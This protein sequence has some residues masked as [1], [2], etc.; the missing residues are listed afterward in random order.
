MYIQYKMFPTWWQAH[1]CCQSQCYIKKWYENRVSPQG[2]LVQVEHP[3]WERWG[4]V[5]SVLNWWHNGIFYSFL[6]YE[7]PPCGN[8]GHE[9]N[10]SNVFVWFCFIHNCMKAQSVRLIE[11]KPQVNLMLM[12]CPLSMNLSV[13]ALYM[14]TMAFLG[15][16]APNTLPLNK[17]RSSKSLLPSFILNHALFPFINLYTNWLSHYAKYTHKITP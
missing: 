17:S 6:G 13:F 3:H 5:L 1:T 2:N 9:W 4:G 15:S 14:M 12:A 16:L 7:L 8:Q 10:G 11:T